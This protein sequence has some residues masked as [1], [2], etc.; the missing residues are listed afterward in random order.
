MLRPVNPV[1][2]PISDELTGDPLGQLHSSSVE[3]HL[4]HV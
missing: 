2:W 4:N 3:N 1:D